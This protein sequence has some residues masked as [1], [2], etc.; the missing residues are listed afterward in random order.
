MVSK[1]RS[2]KTLSK[3]VM[4]SILIVIIYAIFEFISSIIY[5]VSHDVLTGCMFGLFG[6]EIASC[7]FIKIYKM[8]TEG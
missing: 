5:G 8:K 2:L 3:F 7:G 4:I 1:I 6:T